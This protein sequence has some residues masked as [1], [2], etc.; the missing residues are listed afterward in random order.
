MVLKNSDWYFNAP[1]L[2]GTKCDW[3]SL[4][5]PPAR[6]PLQI[7]EK[8]SYGRTKQGWLGKGGFRNGGHGKGELGDE[9]EKS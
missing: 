7:L 3:N 4:R 8:K 9:C 6:S 2:T 1:P 5:H